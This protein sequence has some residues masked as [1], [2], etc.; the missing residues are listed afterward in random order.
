MEAYVTKQLDRYNAIQF[1]KLKS[2]K[3]QIL[4]FYKYFKSND[5]S[6]YKMLIA[7]TL[8]FFVSLFVIMIGFIG[9]FFSNKHILPNL[10]SYKGRLAY[11]GR[12]MIMITIIAVISI[13][14]KEYKVL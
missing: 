2:M 9:A 3:E 7:A 4:A 13:A 5:K 6:I 1:D 14:A 8:I 11:I 10:R 12:M